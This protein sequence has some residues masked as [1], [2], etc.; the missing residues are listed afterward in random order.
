M[1]ISYILLF[2]PNLWNVMCVF[3]LAI[4]QVLSSYTWLVA[5]MMDSE[6]G[7]G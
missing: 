6:G 2:I 5:T 1:T 7:V 4:F 3:K